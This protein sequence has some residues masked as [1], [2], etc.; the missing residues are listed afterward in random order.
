MIEFVPIS[1]L[2]VL[3]GRLLVELYN[4]KDGFGVFLLLLL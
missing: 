1:I 4:L 3:L 2:W